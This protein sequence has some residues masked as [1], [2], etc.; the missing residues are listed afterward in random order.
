MFKSILGVKDTSGTK[1]TEFYKCRDGDIML[2]DVKK[3]RVQRGVS[4]HICI[5]K[6]KSDAFEDKQEVAECW[7]GDVYLLAYVDFGRLLIF[8]EQR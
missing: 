4:R 1:I 5:G 7:I 8:E 2:E 3:T 6:F